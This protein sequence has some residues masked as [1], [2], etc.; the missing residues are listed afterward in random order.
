[1]FIS[2]FNLRRVNKYHVKREMYDNE[3]LTFLYYYFSMALQSLWD[4][5]LLHDHLPVV[6]S[7]CTYPPVCDTHP[8]QVLPHVVHPP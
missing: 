4:L 5:G 3:A 7:V 1:M 6:P 2:L 8:P